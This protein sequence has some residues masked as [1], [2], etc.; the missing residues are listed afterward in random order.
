MKT[1]QSIIAKYSNTRLLE[2]LVL[3]YLKMRKINEGER[4]YILSSI[5]NFSLKSEVDYVQLQIAISY[6]YDIAFEDV[7]TTVPQICD[8]NNLPRGV[9]KL[10]PKDLVLSEIKR[11]LKTS[12]FNFLK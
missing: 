4:K 7:M 9:G 1:L 10:L 6:I 2:S 3:D 12:P 11:Y 8:E 5:V